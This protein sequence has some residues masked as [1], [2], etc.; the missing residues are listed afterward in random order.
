LRDGH[1]FSGIKFFDCA[2]DNPKFVDLITM[3]VS[4]NTT[5]KLV[6]KRRK[7]VANRNERNGRFAPLCESS[8]FDKAILVAIRDGISNNTSLKYLKLSGMNFANATSA[9]TR[10]DDMENTDNTDGL[11]NDNT[12]LWC[13]SLV[14]N[15]S[16]L[17]L[18]LSGSNFAK[19]T[20]KSLSCAIFRNTTLQS[21]NL[22]RCC[23]DDQSLSKI[24]QS[25]KEHPSLIKLNLSWNFLGKSAS[26]EALDAVAEML[27]FSNSKLE[28]LDL[29][30]QRL[31]GPKVTTI[32]D[33]NKEK[34]ETGEERQKIALKNSLDALSANKTLRRINLSGNIGCFSDLDSVE[35]LS[36]CLASNTGLV[37][38][39]VSSCHLTPLGIHYVAKNCIPNCGTKL[40][41][42]VLF[43]AEGNNIS[44]TNDEKWTTIIDSLE[45][46]LQFN[47]T[48]ESLGELGNAS[49]KFKS[50]SRL[51]YLLNENRAGRRALQTDD[52][53]LAAWP[54]ILAR[55]SRLEYDNCHNNENDGDYNNNIEASLSTITSASVVFTL[56][57]GPILLE[58]RR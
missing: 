44:I 57:H 37:Y 17:H 11:S 1:R 48:L 50:R 2:I 29:S 5:T 8:S 18:D 36:L 39:D 51:Q 56:L 31:P 24:L 49:I 7:S 15:N 6:I 12:C 41:S 35:S 46:G 40:K 34:N 14:N 54:N 45:R 26:T 25:V 20:I 43:D 9:T 23:L 47:S 55:A 21:L 10:D 3:I 38:V 19:S 52:L 22:S 58:R 4:Q 16:L 42:L 53:P 33:G 27:R 13:E 30:N 28:C 32:V